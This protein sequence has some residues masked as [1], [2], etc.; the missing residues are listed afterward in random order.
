MAT[1]RV[2]SWRRRVTSVWRAA[3]ASRR[4]GMRVCVKSQRQAAFIVVA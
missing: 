3:A 4:R 2:A 1:S